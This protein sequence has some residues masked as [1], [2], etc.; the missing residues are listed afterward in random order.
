MVRAHLCQAQMPACH[1]RSNGIRAGLY[2]VRDNAMMAAMQAVHPFY[3]DHITARPGNFC[4]HGVQAICQIDYFRLSGSIDQ[5]GLPPGQ[6]G[7][8]HRIFGCPDRYDRKQDFCPCQPFGRTCLNIAIC[9]FDNRAHF[10]HR[11]NMQIHWPGTDSTPPWQGYLCLAIAGQKR[12]HHQNGR[13]HLAN[14]IIRGNKAGCH[15][16]QQQ[17]IP[18]F[19]RLNPQMAQQGQHQ[20][21]IGQIRHI[22]KAQGFC[23][24]HQS[25]SQQGKGGIFCPA[26]RNFTC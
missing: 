1:R 25:A 4:A 24:D 20:P 8:H 17:I 3:G 19:F 18:V 6:T 13:A 21:R 5:L 10:L 9:Q 7:R 14:Q 2:P 26:N 16:A 23:S 11:A 15:P 12:A 22:A